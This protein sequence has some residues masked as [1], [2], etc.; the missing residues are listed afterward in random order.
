MFYIRIADIN[1]CIK[2]KYEYVER[3]CR[4]YVTDAPQLLD[5]TVEVSNEDIEAEINGSEGGAR[6]AYA[7]AIC[8]Y[9]SICKTLP[10]KFNAY[11]FHSAVIEYNGEGYAFSAKSGTGKSTHIMQWQKRYGDDV[12][13]IN[14]DKP[15]L[16]FV[17]DKL[18]AYGTPWCGKE[19]FNQNS[20]VP[21]KAICF[22]E[23]SEKNWIKKISPDEALI[24]F[25]HQVLPPTDMDM[26]DSFIPLLDR[27]LTEI[28]CYLLGCNI[29]AEA[30]EVA[31]MGMKN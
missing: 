5:M 20:S 9:R 25:F 8:V 28:P 18:Y 30:A 24:R 4:G 23:R 11:L 22:L 13:I 15:I 27:T 3:L 10:E 2:N 21:L 12:R 6:P 16:R 29:S 26:V 14:G 19:G 31:Y 1:I 17:G 7:E